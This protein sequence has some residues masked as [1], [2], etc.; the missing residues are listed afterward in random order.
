MLP[1]PVHVFS[2]VL[3]LL[4]SSACVRRGERSATGP[5]PRIDK[6]FPD[7]VMA[8]QGFNVQ[9][10]GQSALGATGAFFAKGA[11]LLINGHP[12][13]TTV[14]DANTISGLMPADLL[15]KDGT[16]AIT[17]DMPDGRLSNTLP[18]IVLPTTGPAPVL[19][20]LYPDTTTA[21]QGFNVQPNGRSAMGLT[22]S[23][24]LPSAQVLINGQ[25]QET[26]FGDIDRL[27]CFFAEKFYQR[28]GRVKVTVRNPDGKESAALE[29]VVR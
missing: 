28:P 27:G 25:P 4:A 22:G 8:G 2:V 7:K 19:G 12:L 3:M 23:N 6:L 13:P 14:T 18:L 15:Q 1:R 5:L 11:R 10:N 9:A 26:N 21:G 20:K 17:V 29:F 16:Y 24:F